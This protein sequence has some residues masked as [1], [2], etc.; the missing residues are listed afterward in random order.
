M[1]RLDPVPM[2]I[3]KPKFPM[4]PVQACYKSIEDDRFWDNF[5]VNYIHPAK[6]N[7]CRHKLQQKAMEVGLEGDQVG[8]VI[9]WVGV[10]A[11]IG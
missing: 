6:S 4:L 2:K 5:P 1:D 3:F 7:I 8:K 11:E 9:G 10:G